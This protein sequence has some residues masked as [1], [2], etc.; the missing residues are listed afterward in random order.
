[1]GTPLCLVVEMGINPSI[2]VS[3]NRLG[4]PFEGTMIVA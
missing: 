2:G 4:V 1:M 3:D